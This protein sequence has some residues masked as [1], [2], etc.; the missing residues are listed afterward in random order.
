MCNFLFISLVILN[1]TSIVYLFMIYLCVTS[2]TVK[3][4]SSR[5][6]VRDWPSPWSGDTEQLTGDISS[7]AAG[8]AVEPFTGMGWLWHQVKWPLLIW[9]TSLLPGKQNHTC[10]FIQDVTFSSINL[11]HVHLHDVIISIKTHPC[12]HLVIHVCIHSW[13]TSDRLLFEKQ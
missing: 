11:M 5:S 3:S 7:A 4:M 9:I 13:W 6:C 10:D 8:S 2:F 1:Y 12:T